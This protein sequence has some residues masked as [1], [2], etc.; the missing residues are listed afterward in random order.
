MIDQAIFHLGER[1]AKRHKD[2]NVRDSNGSPL[3][4]AGHGDQGLEIQRLVH[5]DQA[6]TLI[7]NIHLT[8]DPDES[9]G[10][11]YKV[12]G[13]VGHGVLDEGP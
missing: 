5:G 3:E 6:R 12:K 10:R 11:T 2:I 1:R 9:E 4:V 8:E 7:R 13:P